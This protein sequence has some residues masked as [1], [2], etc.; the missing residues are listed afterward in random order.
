MSKV[1]GEKFL[2]KFM[3]IDDPISKLIVIHLYC[4]KAVNKLI[5]VK[6]KRSE[7]VLQW[8]SSDYHP[9][10]KANFVTQIYFVYNM[11]WIEEGLYNNLFLLNSWR[12][13]YSH[14]IDVDLDKMNYDFDM[15][16]NEFSFQDKKDIKAN[17]EIIAVVT[18]A[19]LHNC[20]LQQH[21]LNY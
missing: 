2:E 21:K 7:K 17:A 5:E 10:K 15:L 14:N 12:N 16:G 4:E 9:L 19:A 1:T 8:K 18:I 3:G 6:G 13:I 20:L 11:G